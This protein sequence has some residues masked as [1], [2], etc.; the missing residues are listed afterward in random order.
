MPPLFTILRIVCLAQISFSGFISIR[1]FVYTLPEAGV[2]AY[3]QLASFLLAVA[4]AVFTIRLLQ[5]NYPDIPVA[6]LQ[7]TIFNWLFLINFLLLSFHFAYVISDARSLLQVSR[8]LQLPLKKFPISMFISL[9]FYSIVAILQIV[10][11]YG[12]FQL[13]R[14]LYKNFCRELQELEHTA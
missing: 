4:L 3:V 1:F 12:L 2:E 14:T 9:F 11:L 7:K 8:Q 6:G 10:I 13:R 5:R